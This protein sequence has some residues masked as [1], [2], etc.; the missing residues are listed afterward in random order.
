[1]RVRFNCP[2]AGEY[3][4]VELIGTA[5]VPAAADTAADRCSDSRRIRIPR[6]DGDP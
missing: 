5:S 2:A 4:T 6:A 1:M 3:R